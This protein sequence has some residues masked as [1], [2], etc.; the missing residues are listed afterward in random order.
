MNKTKK[1]FFS[2]TVTGN[3]TRNLSLLHMAHGNL[4]GPVL[5]NFHSQHALFNHQNY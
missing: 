4:R 2:C 3:T 5:K 1:Y